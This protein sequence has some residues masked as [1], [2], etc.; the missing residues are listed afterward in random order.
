MA[1]GA[2]VWHELPRDQVTGT[3]TAVTVPKP[4]PTGRPKWPPGVWPSRM[5]LVWT[6]GATGCLGSGF[7]ATSKP[8]YLVGTNSTATCLGHPCVISEGSWLKVRGEHLSKQWPRS[9]CHMVLS[10]QPNNLNRALNSPKIP[11]TS[12]NVESSP[13]FLASR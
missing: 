2:N 13:A 3:R 9:L 4:I 10:Q 1:S 5:N 12:N 6:M 8:L 7:R 11:P